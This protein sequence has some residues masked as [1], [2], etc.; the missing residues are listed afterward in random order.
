MDSPN[1]QAVKSLWSKVENDDLETAVES[2][3][4]LCHEDVELRPYVAGGQTLRGRDEIRRYF[5][6]RAAEGSTLHASAW[7]FEGRSDDVMVAGSIRVQRG[8]GSIADAQ[9][10]WRFAFDGKRIRHAE[11]EPLT[12][13][14]G[15]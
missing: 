14:V 10:S 13:S 7:N 1:V 6:A 4:S 8:D 2:F 11:F 12:T 9:V 5:R 15:R 3:L